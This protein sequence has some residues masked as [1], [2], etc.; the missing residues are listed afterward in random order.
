MAPSDKQQREVIAHFSV[1]KLV[2][3]WAGILA[4]GVFMFFWGR[5]VARAGFD[6]SSPDP[7][8]RAVNSFGN[9]VHFGIVLLAVVC[10][11]LLLFWAFR[12][13]RNVVLN[14]TDAVW[15]EQGRLVC[16]GPKPLDIAI[17]D[18]KSAELASQFISN[19]RTSVKIEAR[20]IALSMKDG[21]EER[22]DLGPYRE[23]EDAIIA[24][25]K[26]RIG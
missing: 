15:I 11:G 24:P 20:Y 9:F 10:L 8:E 3:G 25:I 17:G 2:L 12:S 23:I 13:T 4:T 21:K 22:L 19:W 16:R 14:G 18:I 1:A 7:T 5:N 6:S 26:A